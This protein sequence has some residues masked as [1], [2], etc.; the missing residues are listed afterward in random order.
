M[1]AADFEREARVYTAA[2]KERDAL[3]QLLAVKDNMI[4]TVVEVRT[5]LQRE[6]SGSAAEVEAL[7]AELAA[8]RNAQP[9]IYA[10]PTT[11]PPTV[12]AT[13]V[14]A[15]AAAAGEEV[16]GKSGAGKETPGSVKLVLNVTGQ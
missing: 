3:S 13:A 6:A 14:P 1:D 10:P 11:T 15:A 16:A 8:A 5:R 4:W 7:K 9:V 12:A 2:S